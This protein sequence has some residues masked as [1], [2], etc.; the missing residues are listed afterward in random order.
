M[1]ELLRKYWK[2]L[3]AAGSVVCAVV[4]VLVIWVWYSV[5]AVD[6]VDLMFFFIA[7]VTIGCGAYAILSRN[8]VRAVFALLGT[9][10]GM[11]GLY[12]MLAADFVAVVQLMVYVG[13]ILVLMLFA[14]MLTSRIETVARSSRS[15]GLIGSVGAGLIGF[16]LFG[17]LA[18]VAV[19]A[20]WPRSDPGAFQPSVSQLGDELLSGA[21]LPFELLSIVL[22]GV[23]IGAVVIAR[24]PTS[25]GEEA[26]R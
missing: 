3:F 23:V 10:F 24:L 21:L 12:A 9:F 20:P 8:I 26:D 15:T 4:G 6:M 1:N 7:F 22:L 25:K 17:I 19:L 16:V 2:L 5:E 13:G 18:T 11:A 14:V